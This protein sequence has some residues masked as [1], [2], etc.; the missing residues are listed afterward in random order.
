MLKLTDLKSWE[1]AK[2]QVL[3]CDC[4]DLMKKMPD[5]CVDL[6][7]TDPPY[8]VN[9][10]YDLWQDTEE[11]LKN[12]LEKVMP[13][14]LRIGK[15]VIL[16]PG[17]TNIWKYPPSKWIMCWYY[18]TTNAWNSWGFTSWQPILV[19]GK[20]PYLE[21]SMGARMDVIKD[22]TAPEKWI[23]N[24]GHSCNKPI[25][26]WKKLLLRGSVKETDIIFDPFMGSWTTAR[27]CKDLGRNFIGCELSE[28]YCKIGEDRLRQD[29][30]F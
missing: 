6:V 28:A 22:A 18:G 1:D 11:N 4:L 26:F 30:L 19:Y 3:C 8:G 14:L 27:A 25:T 2:N 23:K 21:N 15:R 12:L 5:K 17:H 10:E 9:Y 13:E 24:V 29:N 7:L 20:D 16:T